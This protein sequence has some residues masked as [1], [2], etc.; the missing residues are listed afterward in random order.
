L[1]QQFLRERNYQILGNNFRI[2]GG[3]LDLIAIQNQQLIFFEVKTRQARQYAENHYSAPELLSFR[4]QQKIRQTARHFLHQNRHLHLPTNLQF[5]LL[6]IH[7]D[8]SAQHRQA[9][10]KHLKNIFSA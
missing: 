3:E 1:A 6:V 9:K 2:R 10:I 7:L 4:Q 8:Q 5:D